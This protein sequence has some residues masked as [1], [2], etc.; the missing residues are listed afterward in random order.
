LH[1]GPHA[2]ELAG[3]AEAL[4]VKFR[5]VIVSM[6]GARGGSQIL[7]GDEP[8][9]APMG[10]VR[11]RAEMPLGDQIDTPGASRSAGS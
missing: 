9:V 8:G 3:R 5:S 7:N 6:P 2:A 1:R 10:Q 11:R 4:P